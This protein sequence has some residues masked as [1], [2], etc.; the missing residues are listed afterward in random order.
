MKL[1]LYCWCT[2]Q[3][4]TP[5]VHKLC[6]NPNLPP[7]FIYWN[8]SHSFIPLHIVYDCFHTTRAELNHCEE[9]MWSTKS[10]IFTNWPFTKKKF[11]NSSSTQWQINGNIRLFHKPSSKYMNWAA[12]GLE[13]GF[14]VIWYKN[15]HAQTHILK[16]SSIIPGQCQSC[17]GKVHEVTTPYYQSPTFPTVFT[18]KSC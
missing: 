14:A 11:A 16:G 15:T 2:W 18:S 1:I 10:K 5:G 6:A 7:V 9:T 8:K 4:S 13:V 3:L 17:Q 12:A